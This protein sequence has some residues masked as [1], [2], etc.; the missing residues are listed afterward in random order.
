MDSVVGMGAVGTLKS[1]Q[2][3]AVVETGL[4]T[5]RCS[6]ETSA[7]ALS[8]EATSTWFT[9]RPQYVVHDKLRVH[10]DQSAVRGGKRKLVVLGSNAHE[11]EKASQ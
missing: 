2:A 3:T 11:G 6:P 1:G 10:L 4:L 8:S 7:A 5:Y 9:Q